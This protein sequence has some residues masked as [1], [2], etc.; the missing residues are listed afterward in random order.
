MG[1]ADTATKVYTRHN[2]IFADAFNFYLS[3]LPVRKSQAGRIRHT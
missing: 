3:A 2:N 1:K